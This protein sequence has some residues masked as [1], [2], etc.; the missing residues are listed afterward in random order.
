MEKRKR[1]TIN[2]GLPAIELGAPPRHTAY[3]SAPMR[4][5]LLVGLAAV[6]LVALVGCTSAVSPAATRPPTAA[7]ATSLAISA[8]PTVAATI[9]AMSPEIPT[10]LPATAPDTSPSAGHA[11]TIPASPAVLGARAPVTLDVA[12]QY[13]SGRLA[14]PR[15][16]TLPAGFTANVF[17]AGLSSPRFMAIGPGGTIFVTGMTGGQIYALPDRNSDGVADEIQLWA[18]GLRQPNG[19][20]F[21][22][23]YLYVGETNQVVRFRVGPDGARQGDSEPVVPDLPSGSGHWTRTV[24]FGPDGRLF[25]AVGSSC[26][27][28]EETDQRRAAISVYNA[29]GAD[30]RVF[31]RGLRNA[32]GFVWHPSTSEMW[33]TNNGRDQLGDDLPFETV[34]QVRDG[35]NAGWP[36][37]YPAP[38]GLLPDPEFGQPDSCQTVDPP[39]VTFQAHS[40]PLGLRFYDGNSF[41]EAVRG[42]LFVALHGSWNRSAPVGYKVIRIPFAG[43]T[44]GQAED[45]VTGWMASEG[46]RESV[47]G[48]PV[49]VLVAPDGALLVSDD[50]GGAIYRITYSGT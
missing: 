6:V 43:G 2:L 35:G 27:V 7:A 14:E 26:N 13:R 40:A 3:G 8:A 25:V 19:L 50:D 42:D 44:P 20:A 9:A 15:T 37:C 39:A 12:P 41:P 48:R 17:V 47:W 36:N 4:T 29:D 22:E 34:Y 5:P 11:P 23:G 18:E 28:C 32:V 38:G 30:G 24:G 31:M 33:A 16:L 46:N 49:D 21:H 1:G 45:F 10:A